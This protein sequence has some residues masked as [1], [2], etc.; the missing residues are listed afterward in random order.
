MYPNAGFPYR[1]ISQYAFWCIVAPLVI[2][3]YQVFKG[4]IY[5]PFSIVCFDS[6]RLIMLRLSGRLFILIDGQV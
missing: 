3:I 5:S 1:N 6:L 4:T 2:I